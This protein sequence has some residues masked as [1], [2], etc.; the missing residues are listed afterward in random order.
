[1][2]ITIAMCRPDTDSRCARPESRKA[3]MSG[4]GTP[5]ITPLSSACASAAAR[6][7]QHRID[8][9]VDRLAQPQHPEHRAG[10]RVVGDDDRAE[11]GAC[12]REV[13]KERVALHVPGARDRR[14]ATAGWTSAR[15]LTTSPLVTGVVSPALRRTRS[16]R[17]SGSAAPSI[18]TASSV[19]RRPVGTASTPRTVP[20]STEA[21]RGRVSSG[22]TMAVA[23]WPAAKPTAAAASITMTA[24]DT[25]HGRA[26]KA[27]I[28]AGGGNRC[29]HPHR[30][31]GAEGEIQQHAG[32]QEHRQ[33]EHEA[34]AL[35]CLPRL[36]AVWSRLSAARTGG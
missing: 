2:P 14:A 1:M 21:V 31:L 6:T 15:T 33:P 28:T 20:C 16:R 34:T 27:A 24:R 30:R 25:G 10:G 11:R 18:R 17:C 8:P 35:G 4:G 22:S 5:D 32:A 12:A 23:S 3:A 7:R 36:Q 13:G 26:S 29:A 9:P 19:T